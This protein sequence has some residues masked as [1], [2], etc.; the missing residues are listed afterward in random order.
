MAAWA[1]L[2]R[3]PFFRYSR[4][5]SATYMTMS[6]R[7]GFEDL[8]DLR[9]RRPSAASSTPIRARI[10]WAIEAP[11]ESTTWISRSGSMSR[12]IWALL[13]V[14]DSVPAAMDR[15]DR[16]GAVRERRL[17]GLLELAR[18]GGRRRRERRVR[19]DHPLPERLGREL[20]PG[21]EASRSRS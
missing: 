19:R 9:G 15:D 18:R 12:A 17:V 14:P 21:L 1:P 10:P 11:S 4:V 16:V 5:S 8:G 7:A 6:G 13:I 20:D 3:P 2:I